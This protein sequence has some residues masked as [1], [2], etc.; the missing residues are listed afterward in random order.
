MSLRK[1]GVAIAGAAFILAAM[2]AKA[3]K[4]YVYGQ[5]LPP[6]HNVN[7]WGLKPLVKELGD[8]GIQ[9]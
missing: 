9:W 3:D 2:P 4:A 5:W 1:L 6:K 8:K 7:L